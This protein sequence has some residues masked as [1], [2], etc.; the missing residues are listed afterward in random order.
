MRKSIGLVF[1]LLV[2]L[3]GCRTP[4]EPEVPA[5]ELR[6]LVVEGYLDTEGLK[7]EL[8]L[9]RTAPLGAASAFIPEL[10]AKAVLKSASGQLFQLIEKGA[11]SYVFEKNIDEKQS[12]VLE[13]ELSSGERYVSEGLQPIVTP[14]IIN[15]GFKRD[16]EGVEVFLSTQGNA[17]ADDFLWTFEETW[18]YRPRIRTAYIYVPEL[19]NVRDR[20]DAEQTSLCFKTE[21]SPG[22]LLETSS[23]FRDQVVFQ[24]TITEI[25]TGDQRIMERYSILISQKGL[26]SK[27]V[28]F[29]EILKKN[30]EDI[31]SIFSP[32][33]SLIGG[34]IKSLDADKNPV[35][36]QVSL[37]VIRQKRIYI[38]LVEVSPWNYLDPRFND[39]VIGEAAVYKTDYQATFGNGAIVP[40]VPLIEGTTIV[41]YYPSSR[42]CTDCSL[43]ASKLKPSFWAD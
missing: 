10:R 34:N 7:S 28:P 35:I 41:A 42:K 37:G 23:R 24:K 8:K 17:N 14:E 5:T 11:G 3:L 12:Y 29:W 39:C 33:P 1:I 26:A 6:V 4:Y 20:K 36:G 25:P 43:Y 16:E 32:L 13:I 30:T 9:S 19:K 2:T 40:V 27:D 18:I 21:P 15:A 31:G 38:N 22:I